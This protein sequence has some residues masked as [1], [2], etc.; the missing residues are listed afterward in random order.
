MSQLRLAK[1]CPRWTTQARRRSRSSRQRPFDAIGRPWALPARAARHGR[2]RVRASGLA[3]G[4]PATSGRRA[5]AL[6]EAGRQAHEHGLDGAQHLDARVVARAPRAR[7]R[8]QLVA[9]GLASDLLRE[10]AL[11]ALVQLAQV[12]AH[13][14]QV[15]QRELVWVVCLALDAL[16]PTRARVE[17]VRRPARAWRPRFRSCLFSSA[18]Q[19][20]VRRW[21]SGVGDAAALLEGQ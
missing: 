2:R 21:P 16:G 8:A 10:L 17:R 20:A 13:L 6:A 15:G 1:Q 12:H 19:G 3:G 14:E 4:Q 11:E 7:A 9:L 18:D 5:R